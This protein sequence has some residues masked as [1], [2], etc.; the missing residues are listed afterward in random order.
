MHLLAAKH[1]LGRPR[2]AENSLPAGRATGSLSWP[3]VQSSRERVRTLLRPLPKI[4][5]VSVVLFFGVHSALFRAIS[6][7]PKHRDREVA[8]VPLLDGCEGLIER[9]PSSGELL[10]VG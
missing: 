7:L 9:L 6:Q 1:T 3:R 2:A 4:R 8:E 5:P 10:Q